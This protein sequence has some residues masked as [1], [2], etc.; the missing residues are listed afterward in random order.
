VTAETGRLLEVRG[1]VKRFPGVVALRGVRLEVVPGQIHALVGENGAGK[2]TLIKVLSGVYPP[3]DGEVLIHG[4]PVEIKTTKQAQELG[5]TTIHQELLLAPHLTGLQNMFLGHELRKTGL[6]H[7]LGRLDDKQMALRAKPLCD[8]FGLD[9]RVLGRPVEE[10]SALEKRVV[11]LLKALI[12]KAE[13]IIMDEITAG[14][15]TASARR[16]SCT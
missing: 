3:D 2:S 1:I 11:M 14:L 15:P 10:L 9:M 13:L 6:G 7:V 8:E 16:C 12:F 5:I 4:E